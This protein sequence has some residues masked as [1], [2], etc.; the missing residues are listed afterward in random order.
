[1][2]ATRRLANPFLDWVLIVRQ[3]PDALGATNFDYHTDHIEGPGVQSARPVMTVA[4]KL[5]ETPTAIGL[6]GATRNTPREV[7][8]G[9]P[10]GSSVCFHSKTYHRVIVGRTV[11]KLV[12]HISDSPPS[13]VVDPDRYHP[14]LPTAQDFAFTT[15]PS[16]AR[17]SMD[18]R[19]RMSVD[20]TQ[21]S[22]S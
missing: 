7:E 21:V 19:L 16:G 10:A 17:S 4:V 9:K 2:C 11:H 20:T 1:M 6:P 18:G 13:S 22:L 14:D 5:D 12:L 8:Y 3:G 15:M